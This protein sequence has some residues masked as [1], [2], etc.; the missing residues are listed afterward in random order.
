M[1][2][3]RE[4]Q[5]IEILAK[6]SEEIVAYLSDVADFYS[7]D[8]IGA[9]FNWTDGTGRVFFNITESFTFPASLETALTHEAILDTFQDQL[10]AWFEIA[11][12]YLCKKNS[13][14]C[15]E[16]VNF[17]FQPIEN[18]TAWKNFWEKECKKIT[19]ALTANSIKIVNVELEQ[20]NIRDSI[21][22]TFLYKIQDI[23][24]STRTVIKQQEEIAHFIIYVNS[25]NPN[26]HKKMMVFKSKLLKGNIEDSL[27]TNASFI[28]KGLWEEKEIQKKLITQINELRKNKLIYLLPKGEMMLYAG[29]VDF[30]LGLPKAAA[31]KAIKAI[32]ADISFHYLDYLD[33]NNEPPKNYLMS[34]IEALLP[35]ASNTTKKNN[36]K[37]LQCYAKH[38]SKI[39]L[40]ANT[41]FFS[42]SISTPIPPFITREKSNI[43]YGRINDDSSL[44]SLE[45]NRLKNSQQ[46]NSKSSKGKSLFT[47][48]SIPITRT[49]SAL[50]TLSSPYKP[51]RFI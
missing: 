2:L 11:N 27:N 37:L 21:A 29:L 30:V 35:H 32:F 25:I 16:I 17:F 10:Y 28:N 6:L 22:G 41:N 39:S 19:A 31:N 47:T 48:S 45:E 50:S 12:P 3:S 33:L 24:K 43:D 13:K 1:A 26:A 38:K 36:N 40:I 4:E 9:A 42:T 51:K 20:K 5:T 46:S 49:P 18:S 15:A 14:K 23:W 34:T 8:H 7:P 44:Q